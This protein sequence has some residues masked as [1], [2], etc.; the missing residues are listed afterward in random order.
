MYAFHA[1]DH[2]GRGIMRRMS[3]AGIAVVLLVGLAPQL[4]A[5][6]EEPSKGPAFGRLKIDAEHIE[7]LILRDERGL[8]IPFDRPSGSVE[9]AVGT[10]RV[11]KIVLDGGYT[12]RDSR[13]GSLKIREGEETVLR[14]GA[15]LSHRVQ[16]QRR[17]RYLILGYALRGQ[18]GEEYVGRRRTHPPR[19]VVRKDG[20]QIATG[21]FE[22]G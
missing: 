13:L 17:G 9:L 6:Q 10:Y 21:R 11:T 18:G 19:F 2:E 5:G 15:P 4:S 8:A 7:R 1:I 16:A 12:S 14:A 22:Y 20:K 3:L